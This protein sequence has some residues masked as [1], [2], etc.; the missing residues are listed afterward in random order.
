MLLLLLLPSLLLLLLLLLLRSLCFGQTSC[1]THQNSTSV[2][3]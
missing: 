3:A 1:T 2:Q